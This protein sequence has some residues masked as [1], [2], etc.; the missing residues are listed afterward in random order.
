MMASLSNW[1]LWACANKICE[2]YGE[3]AEFYAAQRADELLE[4]G[5]FDGYNAWIE[6]RNRVRDLTRD[7]VQSIH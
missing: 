3:D 1:E 5:D 7:S 2:Q 6:I 4:L